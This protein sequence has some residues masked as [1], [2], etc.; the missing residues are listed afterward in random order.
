MS[1]TRGLETWVSHYPMK[2]RRIA[3]GKAAQKVTELVKRHL[4]S[5]GQAMRVPGG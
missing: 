3:E 2:Q 5:P 1:K 4:Y